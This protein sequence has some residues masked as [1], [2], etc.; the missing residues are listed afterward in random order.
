MSGKAVTMQ[1]TDDDAVRLGSIAAELEHAPA[2][3]RRH[4]DQD[5]RDA[6]FLRI[7]ENR[8]FDALHD[9]NPGPSH[10]E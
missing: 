2:E 7:F 6:R 4:F 5:G 9:A 8:I 10:A 1:V 3:I